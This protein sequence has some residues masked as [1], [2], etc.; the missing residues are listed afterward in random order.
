M[1]WCKHIF[2]MKS[3]HGVKMCWSRKVNFTKGNIFYEAPKTWL[4]CPNC[5]KPRPKNKQSS[6]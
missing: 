4:Y 1:R 3:V 6:K 5:G 2:Y